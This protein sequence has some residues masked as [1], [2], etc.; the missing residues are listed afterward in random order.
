MLLCPTDIKTKYL[1][2]KS[3]GRLYNGWIIEIN[4]KWKELEMGYR[5]EPVEGNGE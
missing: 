2:G 3:K 5:G 4:Y 1:K